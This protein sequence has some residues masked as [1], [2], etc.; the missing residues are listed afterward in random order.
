MRP[1]LLPRLA[2]LAIALPPAFAVPAQTVSLQR[3]GEQVTIL[4]G[5][6][7]ILPADF[8]GDV[9]LP[10]AA[11]L[12]R[13]ESLGQ[14]RVVVEFT[15]DEAPDALAA[16]CAR[17]MAEAG[18]SRATVEPVA[19]AHAQAWEKDERAVLVAAWAEAGVT[20]LRLQLL[21]RARRPAGGDTF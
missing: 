12:V 18:W 1:T 7:A 3:A 13:V 19:G 5:G 15:S 14:D 20:R 10:A 17:S 16:A 11:T 2:V 6:A 21:P 9:F 8:P 4:V